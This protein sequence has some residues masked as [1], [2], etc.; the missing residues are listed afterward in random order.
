MAE[1]LYFARHTKLFLNQERTGGTPGVDDNVWEIPVMDGFSFSQATNASEVSLQEMESTGGLSRRGMAKFNDSLAPAEWSFSTYVRPVQS[2]AAAVEGWEPATS[3][4]FHHSIEE[5]LWANFIA[6]NKYDAVLGVGSIQTNP[7]IPSSTVVGRDAGIYVVTEALGDDYS[8]AGVGACW[9]ITVGATTGNDATDVTI[10]LIAGGIGYTAE[11]ITIPAAEV[12]GVGDLEFT[13][14]TVDSKGVW[15]K[16]ILS[17]TTGT[18]Y[19][20][21]QSNTST[22]GTFD[23]YFDLGNCAGSGQPLPYKIADCVVNSIGIDFDIDGIAMINW[24]G[25][26][27]IITEEVSAPPATITEDINE[28][29]NFIRNRLTTVAITNTSGGLFDASY[30][31][32]LTGGSLAFENNITFLT[33][34]TLCKVDQPIGHV[35][36]NRAISGTFTAYLNTADSSTAELWQDLIGSTDVVTNSFRLEFAI[37]GANTPNLQVIVP[38]AHLEVPA[39]NIEDVIAIETT[40]AGLPSTITAANE[41]T[42]IYTGS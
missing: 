12:G 23:L 13:V 5:A 34:E 18:T 20:F 36:G 10:A 21:A 30:N 6:N 35:T 8:A 15:E 38:T 11:L 17:T 14:T 26:G 4:A 33:P 1:Q 9:E 2:V 31:V 24:S 25:F 27:A 28:T 16:G 37:G 3:D 7:T 29:D 19:S 32:V 22:L 41:A 40:F 39:H 42:I